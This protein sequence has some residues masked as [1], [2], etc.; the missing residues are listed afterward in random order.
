[1]GLFRQLHKSAFW[2]QLL[3]GMVAILALPTAEVA[4][5]TEQSPVAQTLTVSEFAAQQAD[6]EQAHFLSQTQHSVQIVKQAVVFCEFFAKSYRLY[7]ITNPPIRAG[8]FV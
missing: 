7:A 2:S 5:E 4:K 8:P 3:L 1:M 6:I